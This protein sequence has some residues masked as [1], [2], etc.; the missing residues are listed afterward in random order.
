M[1]ENIWSEGTKEKAAAD[2][3][4]WGAE[5]IAKRKATFFRRLL[6]VFFFAGIFWEIFYKKVR[7]VLQSRRQN[8]IL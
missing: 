5:D 6:F 2:M 1:M 3:K 8:A 4:K 7:K